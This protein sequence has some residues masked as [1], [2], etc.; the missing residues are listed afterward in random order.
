MHFHVI[1]RLCADKLLFKRINEGMASDDQVLGICG[2]ALKILA[3][4]AALV[5]DI[6]GIAVRNRP[7]RNLLRICGKQAGNVFVHIGLGGFFVLHQIHRHVVIID[8]LAGTHLFQRICLRL[9]VICSCCLSGCFC[10]LR[11]GGCLRRLF[12]L[13]SGTHSHGKNAR[14]KNGLRRCI[15]HDILFHLSSSPSMLY[16]LF[17][18]SQSA[19]RQ[20]RVLLHSRWGLRSQH[21]SILC[22]TGRCK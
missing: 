7:V 2:A 1:A 8:E 14:C 10:A 11:R 18:T 13:A 12:T 4:D 9:P 19:A 20:C 6:G 22:I 5:I 15:L 21:S 3:V 16:H 17:R